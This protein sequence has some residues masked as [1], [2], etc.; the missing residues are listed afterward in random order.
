M[1]SSCHSVDPQPEPPK[2]FKGRAEAARLAREIKSR[3][4]GGKR[5]ARREKNKAAEAEAAKQEGPAKKKG[6]GK[7]RRKKKRKKG[8][9][10]LVKT[11]VAS[12]ASSEEFGW[13][14]AAE[15]HRRGLHRAK[16]KGYVCDGQ[17]YNWAIFEMHLVVLGFIGILDF[18]H[19]M[20]YLYGAAQACEGKGSEQAWTRYEKWL[21]WAWTGQVKELIKELRQQS[22]RLGEPPQ[23][24]SD[25]DPRKV[26]AEALGYVRNNQER[27]D[28]PRYRQLGLPVFSAGL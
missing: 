24:C 20:A 21:R 13:Q 6:K 10:K 23:G 27:M 8:P 12:M 1:T 4:D 16:R 7:A 26:V 19:L 3:R 25:D 11:V 18:I 15:V 17:K 14:V 5:A 2:K 9:V 22:E 28:Y